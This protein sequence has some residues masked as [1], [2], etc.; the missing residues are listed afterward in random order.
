ML[1]TKHTLT[2]ERHDGPWGQ[3]IFLWMPE[4]DWRNTKLRQRNKREKTRQHRTKIRHCCSLPAVKE[5]RCCPFRL[6]PSIQTGL[7]RTFK[8]ESYELFLSNF[9][10]SLGLTVRAIQPN[11]RI[12]PTHPGSNDSSVC[13]RWGKLPFGDGPARLLFWDNGDSHL[14]HAD[15][16]L[17]P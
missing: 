7:N 14:G 17:S 16:K 10:S 12:N 1:F 6:I 3:F 8:D 4:C 11:S 2:S 15:L 9:Y 13:T 5:L